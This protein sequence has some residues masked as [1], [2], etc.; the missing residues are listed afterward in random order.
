MNVFEMGNNL[1]PDVVASA[2]GAGKPPHVLILG[3]G[4]AGLG[5]G[6]ELSRHKVSCTVVDK[7]ERVGGLART[8][9]F[10]GFRFD[11]GPHRFFTKEDIVNKLWHEVLGPDFIRVPRLTRIFYRGKFFYYPL[12]P[13][14]A[15]MGLGLWSSFMAVV[16]YGYA[17]V[18]YRDREARSFEEWI[19]FHFGRRL[20]ETFFKT[21]TEKV[22]GI[23]CSKIGAEWASQRIRGLNLWRAAKSAVF[24][25]RDGIRT[26]TDEFY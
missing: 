26:L 4:P 9:D 7:H 20:Y 2:A 10:E 23:P 1:S 6:Y 5:A 12:K 15:L 19:T 25:N 13:F 8:V 18:A 16:S 22:W 11:I 14:N 21:Y 24:G 3:A 17:R